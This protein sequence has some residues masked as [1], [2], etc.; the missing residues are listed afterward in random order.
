MS[1]ISVV[2][3][4]SHQLIEQYNEE[5]VRLNFVFQ[6]VIHLIRTALVS[7]CLQLYKHTLSHTCIQNH[8]SAQG[9]YLSLLPF[10]H[11]KEKTA[12]VFEPHCMK[13]Y[14]W[15]N[16]KKRV[17]FCSLLECASERTLPNVFG[18]GAKHF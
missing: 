9:I 11:T 2:W 17:V 5:Q 8:V 10:L 18:K 16:C 3:R 1:V 12:C 4:D 6:G 13:E 15:T 7:L 14:F